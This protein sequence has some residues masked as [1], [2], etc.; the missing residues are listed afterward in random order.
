MGSVLGLVEI[1]HA[2]RDEDDSE[3]GW[4][5]TA[6]TPVMTWAVSEH[7]IKGLLARG[8]AAESML[9][10]LVGIF[11]VFSNMGH[12][13]S[14]SV[15]STEVA[16]KFADKG[17]GF[18]SEL[19]LDDSAAVHT[20]FSGGQISEADEEDTEEEDAGGS[21]EEGE[22]EG[23][24]VG[25]EPEMEPLSLAEEPEPE[26]E[27]EPEQSEAA[28]AGASGVTVK[29]V[30][31]EPSV[32][33]RLPPSEFDVGH[34]IEVIA[35]LVDKCVNEEGEGDSHVVRAESVWIKYM[36]GHRRDE[37]REVFPKRN[38]SLKVVWVD[39]WACLKMRCALQ[40]FPFSIG[41]D[42]TYFRALE[43]SLFEHGSQFGHRSTKYVFR[44]VE[45]MSTEHP[46]GAAYV[47]EYKHIVLEGTALILAGHAVC[48]D[49][50][51]A[52]VDYPPTRWP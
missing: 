29:L 13:Y 7:E 48:D 45:D 46:D 31:A 4:R 1:L 23:S 47:D 36:N 32:E 2:F 49:H 10:R 42:G 52:N 40:V 12:P 28:A 6:E 3:W 39:P 44:H 9:W 16:R 51:I 25:V 37:W 43:T 15:D 20:D 26:L 17:W 18:L 24:S 38:A 30:A 14:T 11:I 50:L 22:R 34:V 41:A 33:V 8:K 19:L 27:P 5:I 21:D 35:A